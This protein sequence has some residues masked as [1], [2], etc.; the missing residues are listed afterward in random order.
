MSGFDQLTAE[1]QKA[2]GWYPVVD[3]YAELV[4]NQHHGPPTYTV[5]DVDVLADHPAEDDSPETVNQKTIVTN[6]EQDL[7]AM[8]LILDTANST[9][10]ANPGSF[11]KDIARM[12]KR[13]GR[14]AIGDYS[15]A[16]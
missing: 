14:T 7:E 3:Q 16:D 15:E 4:D 9:I 13:L 8:Q 10:D 5:R 1:E 12:N 2:E 6:L 11:I